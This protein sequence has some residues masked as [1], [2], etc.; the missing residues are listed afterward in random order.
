[1]EDQNHPKTSPSRQCIKACG[2]PDHQLNIEMIIKDIIVKRNH[3]YR[4]CHKLND[5]KPHLCE[6]VLNVP[7]L[8]L[9]W[10]D[11]FL[12]ALV[13]HWHNSGTLKNVYRD[14]IIHDFCLSWLSSL[15]KQLCQN[16]AS[17]GLLLLASDWY[18][19]RSGTLRHVNKGDLIL[20]V[21]AFWL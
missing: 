14:G 3:Y 10:P 4:I 11:T 9:Y 7:E 17:T 18:H 2:R 8:G 16:Q 15:W 13:R 21:V 12:V 1:M 20:N 19:S 6:H 5:S